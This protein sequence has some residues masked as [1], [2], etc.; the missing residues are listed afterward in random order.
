M[1]TWAS[2]CSW[3]ICLLH[4]FYIWCQ[5]TREAAASSYPQRTSLV[6]IDWKDSNE[7]RMPTDQLTSMEKLRAKRNTRQA[8][9]TRQIDSF[10]NTWH[11]T[12]RS[13]WRLMLS[14]RDIWAKSHSRLAWKLH[15][16]TLFMN[17]LFICI[18]RSIWRLMLS[19]KDTKV[20][21][22]EVCYRYRVQGQHD[23]HF[24]RIRVQEIPTLPE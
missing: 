16:L 9:T 14:R 8:Q 13:S 3:L 17:T 21:R 22:G 7:P 1:A 19:Q 18:M 23:T 15:R 2:Q 24:S 10:T 4:I 20:I 5:I 6:A 12:M 11:I